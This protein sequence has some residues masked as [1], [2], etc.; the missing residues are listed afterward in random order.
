MSSDLCIRLTTQESDLLKMYIEMPA[1]TIY[2]LSADTDI[3]DNVH[4]TIRRK[5]AFW[6]LGMLFT[7]LADHPEI[8]D[9]LYFKIGSLLGFRMFM[10]NYFKINWKLPVEEIDKL[11]IENFDKGDNENILLREMTPNMFYQEK[12]KYVGVIRV[13]K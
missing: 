1:E 13:I 3:H 7:F 5:L 9:K 8:E 10:C 4:P 11:I 6:V 2:A 12:K